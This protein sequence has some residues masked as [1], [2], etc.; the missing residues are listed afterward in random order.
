MATNQPLVI[1]PLRFFPQGMPVDSP[2]GR[3]YIY[4]ILNLSKYVDASINPYRDNKIK[5]IYQYRF[6]EL[7]PKP[8]GILG[9][10]PEMYAALIAGRKT[11]IT[12][13]IRKKLFQAGDI[14]RVGEKW[15]W[16]SPT[17]WAVLYNDEQ[18]VALIDG[19]I[20]ESDSSIDCQL[21]SAV[22]KP[23]TLPLWATRHFLRIKGVET[24]KPSNFT[25]DQILAEGV[26]KKDF[27]DFEPIYKKWKALWL[28][29]YPKDGEQTFEKEHTV[30]QFELIKA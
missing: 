6:S 26:Y 14:V 1:Y 15:R 10:T 27:F 7:T 28:S 9:F 3:A 20:C 30:Y 8:D 17:K 16:T 23:E 25:D 13:P 12:V 18:V 2:I 21:K 22:Q 29:V 11:Q 19:K 4:E 24:Q 5:D